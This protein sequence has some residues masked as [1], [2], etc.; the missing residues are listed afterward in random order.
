M[1]VKI[2]KQN[3]QKQIKYEIADDV[4]QL[5]LD[6]IEVL[7]LKHIDTNRL[8]CVRSR[9]SKT[10]NTI[11]RCHGTAKILQIAFNIKPHYVIEVISEKFDKLDKSEKIKVLIHELMHIPK[12]FGGGF[13]HHDFV[14]DNLVEKLYARYVNAKYMKEKYGLVVEKTK[15]I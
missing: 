13:R 7:K 14:N 9:N 8:A 6:I 4:K 3:R 11:A 12:N 2:K 10:K 1:K 5:V 15:D